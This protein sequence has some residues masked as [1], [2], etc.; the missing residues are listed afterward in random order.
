MSKH[1]KHFYI[2]VYADGANAFWYECARCSGRG[3]T[4]EGYDVTY[5]DLSVLPT[6][7]TCETCVEESDR[8]VQNA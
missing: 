3:Y 6:A 5:A 8:S 1:F 4:E 2:R 7:Y